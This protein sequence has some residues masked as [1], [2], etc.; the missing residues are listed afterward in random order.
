[1]STAILSP[2]VAYE[3]QL[4]ADPE[5]AMNEGSRHFDERSA[6]HRS[7]SKI[8]S[9]LSELGI[10]Y[11]IAGGM[12]LFRHGFRRFTEDVDILVS[13]DGLRRIHTELEGRG[14]LPVFAGSKNLRDTETGVRIEFLI[15]GQ[16]P[17]DGKP[18]PVAFPDP[19]GVDLDGMTYLSLPRLIEIKL[20]SGMT[21]P[22]RL[23]DLADV[24]Q[25][26]GLLNLSAQFGDSLH[27]FVGATYLQLWQATLGQPR[28]FFKALP[29]KQTADNPDAADELQ[30]MLR[31][32]V[33]FDESRRSSDYQYLVTTDPEV[34]H[35]Y[36][37]HDESEFFDLDDE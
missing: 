35:R 12:A 8:T 24:Q 36:E 19:E 21:N 14:Y 1:M 16:F 26:I 6:V 33:T 9:K 34:A 28:R 22:E 11:A 29:M 37:M 13:K 25:L 5:W 32:G 7:L 31:D 15:S 17:G 30:A 18:K 4:D 27:P 10:P 2:A 3:Q 20:A 23:K